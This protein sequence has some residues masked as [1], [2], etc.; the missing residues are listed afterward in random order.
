MRRVNYLEDFLQD[1]RYGLRQLRRSPGFTAVATLTLALGIGVNTAIFSVINAVMLRMLPVESPE[2][3]VQVGFQGKHSGESFVGESFPYPLFKELRRQNQVFTDIAAF[4]YWDSLDAR[5]ANAGSTNERVKAQMV[6]VNFFSM[7][8]LKAVI[9]RTFA[10]DE[11]NGVGAHPVAVISYALWTRMFA[12][13][14]AVLGKKLV[15]E[16]TPFTIIGVAPA[17][18]D[19]VSPDRTLDLWVPVSMQPQVLPGR[20]RLTEDDTNWLTLMARLRPGVSVE[21]ARAGL[22]VV[23][24]RMQREHDT[25]HW[26]ERDRED[27]FTHRIVLLPA[28]RGT[29]YLRREFSR[30]LFLL[31]AMVGLVLLIACVNVANL[32]LARASVRRREIAVRLALGAGPGRLYGNYSPRASCWR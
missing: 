6:S 18:F 3:L 12:R 15:I 13:D 26:S 21:Q 8:G 28:A 14:P 17:H 10:P 30:P 19:G 9:G 23:Y 2:Q 16:N 31:M 4:D 11:D 24:Q 1:I 22:D 29:D 7:L 5:P 20:V 32:L 25:S 27:F